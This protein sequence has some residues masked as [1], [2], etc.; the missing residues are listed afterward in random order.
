MLLL[1]T[2]NPNQHI[3][4][5]FLRD[6]QKPRKEDVRDY[7][8]RNLMDAI[9][10]SETFIEEK[11]KHNKGD[12][13]SLLKAIKNRLGFVV[14]DTEDSKIV[15]KV[16]EVLNSRGLAVDWL[17][18]CK[19]VLMGRAFELAKSPD[20]ARSAIESIQALWGNIYDE[21]ATGSG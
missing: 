12:E 13:I 16:F 19:S 9:R 7:A 17:D 2:N 6:G 4:D 11:W 8:D 20:A 3:F 10:D 18:K 21:I 5:T 15:Y 14:F 1:Q